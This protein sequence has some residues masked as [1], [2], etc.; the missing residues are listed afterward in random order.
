VPETKERSLESLEAAFRNSTKLS[1]ANN[2]PTAA[3]T[4][5]PV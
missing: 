4:G 1:G 5:G 2:N 3:G